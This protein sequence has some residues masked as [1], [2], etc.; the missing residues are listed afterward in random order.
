LAEA[1]ALGFSED[2]LTDYAKLF[3]Q[4]TVAVQ[5]TPRDVDIEVLLGLDAA[6]QAIKEFTAKNRETTVTVKADTD[7]AESKIAS[8]AE[9][10]W[11][12]KNIVAD[13]IDT[14]KVDQYLNSWLS[15]GRTLSMKLDFSS[16]QM[17]EAQAAASLEVFK[18][19][20]AIRSPLAESYREQY[21]IL[22]RI[23]NNLRA[24]GMATGGFVSGPGT[25]TSDSIPAMLSNG[26]F[27]MNARSVR[28]YG[29]DF[30]NALNQQRVGFSRA[31][32][33]NGSVSGGG[34]GVVALSPEDRAL[35][36]AVI[37][38]PVTL[39]ADNTKIAQSAN[40]GNKLLSQRGLK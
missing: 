14:T 17:V 37:N 27:V 22:N 6:E 30:F 38:R 16:S 31:A 40:D 5:D 29:V 34:A 7:P 33:A 25:S 3:D 12:F 26:E 20:A 13:R 23:A 15:K 4:F 2:Q 28:T 32:S 39:Y 35:L 11:K 21:L 9:M 18:A 1:K 24:Q 10:Q 36:R 8:V 19:L